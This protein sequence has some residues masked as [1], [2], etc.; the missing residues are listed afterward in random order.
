MERTVIPAN[1]SQPA[2][3]SPDNGRRRNAS[4][5]LRSLGGPRRGWGKNQPGSLRSL[6][7][8]RRSLRQPRQARRRTTPEARSSRPERTPMAL[9]KSQRPLP[10]RDHSGTPGERGFPAF[11]AW[12]RTSVHRSGT[13]VV[14]A[15]DSDQLLALALA[16]GRE[17]PHL[18]PV[19]THE[20]IFAA[21]RRARARAVRTR[22]GLRG[23]RE[24]FA[25]IL[26]QT[27][28]VHARLQAEF[29]R[30]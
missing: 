4:R 7:G 2:S 22:E 12:G 15:G 30:K 10:V 20:E 27:T 13:G 21:A 6:G 17:R 11:K 19:R 1:T 24:R 14:T 23:S 29:A 5:S 18:R 8:S 3:S 28:R 9:T 26:D 16:R 25:A